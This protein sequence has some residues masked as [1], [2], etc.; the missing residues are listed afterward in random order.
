MNQKDQKYTF[1][2]SSAW[3]NYN[4]YL[5]IGK[6]F[7]D[8]QIDTINR[9]ISIIA[10][11]DNS[12]NK[13][14]KGNKE[15][16]KVNIIERINIL[17]P[18]TEPLFVGEYFYMSIK[19]PVIPFYT[20]TNNTIIDPPEATL[21]EA[22]IPEA[23]LIEMHEGSSTMIHISPDHP[24]LKKL[25]SVILYNSE[26]KVMS[27]YQLLDVLKERVCGEVQHDE[28]HIKR[29]I[30]EHIRDTL[31][32]INWSYF[33]NSIV[34]MSILNGELFFSH[35]S[36]P[37]DWCVFGH[38]VDTDRLISGDDRNDKNRDD[39]D[40]DDGKE[41]DGDQ[42]IKLLASIHSAS[43]DKD[44]DSFLGNFIDHKKTEYIS[45][46][47]SHKYTNVSIPDTF[48][49]MLT[50]YP[51]KEVYLNTIKRVLTYENWKRVTPFK[52]GWITCGPLMVP[53]FYQPWFPSN[54]K[55]TW[56]CKIR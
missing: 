18:Y 29:H 35:N 41:D 44:E 47:L 42:P 32:L 40:R 21:P 20:D 5:L 46:F 52:S 11:I 1:V 8:H 13:D 54:L 36:N 15:I 12:I 23:T 49:L 3:K 31:K 55:D 16:N 26:V 33:N 50:I 19:Q 27:V 45:P 34:P 30:L 56:Y 53:G 9:N 17:T 7:S 14:D 39:G 43:L 37:L 28:R 24:Y 22:T 6:F 38:I 25:S 4:N 48:T 2:Y 10:N 51:N